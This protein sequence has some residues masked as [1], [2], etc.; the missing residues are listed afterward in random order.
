MACASKTNVDMTKGVYRKVYAGFLWGERISAVSMVAEA[1]FWR[2]H[3]IADDLGNLPGEPERLA[4]EAGGRR[5]IT[6]KQAQNLTDDLAA[7]GLIVRYQVD[8]AD[9][10]HI[11]QFEDRQPGR[12][13][14]SRIQRYPHPPDE[15]EEQA[16]T[17]KKPQIRVSRRIRVN[18]S[19][20]E[21]SAPPNP[22]P[23]PNPI[24]SPTPIPRVR[25]NPTVS[26]PRT[27]AAARFVADRKV[28]AGDIP[29]GLT[30]F[31]DVYPPHRTRHRPKILAAWEAGG[32][33]N[34]ADA[35]VAGV[36]AHKAG[37]DWG[38]G[39]IPNAETFL[40]ERHWEATPPPKAQRKAVGGFKF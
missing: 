33:E 38:D 3:A 21:Q 22:S 14:G 31:L 26:H 9:Y 13:N 37:G 34:D 6:P 7:V 27:D 39:I 40:T 30:R 11:L 24:P 32:C 10:I 18:P 5:R 23:I 28:A 1:W 12:P 35:I 20:P 15:I 8:G 17:A 2:L 4:S 29:P 16:K 36:H 25:A 19:E